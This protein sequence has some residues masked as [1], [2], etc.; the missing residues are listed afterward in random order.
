MANH[1]ICKASELPAG[2]RKIVELE[3]RSIGIFNIDNSYYAMKNVCPHYKAPLCKGEV[4][5]MPLPSEP[6]T[7]IWAREGEIVRCPWHGWEFDITTGKSIYNP[8]KWM[9]KTYEVTVEKDAE[10]VETFEVT[11]ES[12]QVVVHI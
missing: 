7:F 6:G 12:G 11:V 5:G 2:D 10:S 4:T 8:H 3:G 9:V 1:I